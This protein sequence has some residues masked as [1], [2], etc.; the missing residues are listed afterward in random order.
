MKTNSL[1]LLVLFNLAAFSTLTA[2]V[3]VGGGKGLL[4]IY[5]AETVYPGL[6]YINP[7]YSFYG[8]EKDSRYSED[9]TLNLSFT[10]GL[11]NKFELFLHTVPYQ[12]DQDHIWGPIGDTDIG[13]KYQVPK[14]GSP[15]QFAL[16]GLVNFPTAI[17]HNV[18]FEPYSSDGTGWTLFGVANLDMKN[19]SAAIPLKFSFNIGYRDHDMSDRFFAEKKD[20]LV[21]GFGLKFPVRSSILYSELTGEIFINNTDEVSFSENLI[22]FTQGIR[23]L[24]PSSLVFD[25]AADFELGGASNDARII[26]NEFIKDYA[27]WKITLGATYRTTLFKH[28][29]PQEKLARKQKQEE[30]EKLNSIR[31]KREQVSKDLE[32]LKKN[33]EKEK[34]KEETY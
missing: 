5:D 31:Q 22:R 29:T 14:N 6:L 15:L 8:Q 27:D 7:F 16:V 1:I 25:L 30:N 28:L 26:A 17:N 13:L 9:H 19:T 20:Q 11:S 23:F 12:D 34:R 2:Q 24:G 32:E 3:S 10:L 18:Q 21:G 4:R 33:L